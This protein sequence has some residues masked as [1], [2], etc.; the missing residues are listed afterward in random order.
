VNFYNSFGKKY[1][2]RFNLL[3]IVIIMI[4]TIPTGS[5]CLE[6]GEVHLDASAIEHDG[7]LIGL[8]MDHSGHAIMLNDAELY[9]DDGPGSGVPEGLD[10]RAKV[11]PWVEELKKGIVI[12]KILVLDNP[13]TFSARLLFEGTE[14]KGNRD[15]LHIS[16]N[17]IE[18]LRP[19]SLSAYPYTVQYTEY[20]PYDC[21]YFIDMP[22]GALRK[23]ENEVLLWAESDSTSWK[24]HISS[25][26]EFARGSLTRPH[27][28]NRS[29]KSSDGGKTWTD[30]RLGPMGTM[31]GE[32]SVRFNLNHY[33]SSGQYISPVMEM[34]NDLSPLKRKI[35]LEKFRFTAGIE[36]PE[37]TSAAVQVRFGS[38]PRSEDPSWTPWSASDNTKEFT[39]LGDRRYVQW[40]VD[41]STANPLKTP[42]IKECTLSASWEDLS[43]NEELGISVEVVHN[44]HVVR[45]SYPF[46][47]EN[48]LHPE[49]EKYRKNAQLD[50]IVEGA[51]SEFEVM[52]RL[53]NWAYR[54]PVTSDKYSWNWN[55]VTLLQKG[56]K[57][58]PR[59]QMDYKARRRDAMCLYSNQALIGALLAFGHQARHININSEA[60]SG[61]E[62][63][64][65]WSNEFNKWIYLDATRDYY[66][67]DRK[68]GIPLNLLEIHNLLAART[69]NPVT[70]DRPSIME[71]ETGTTPTDETSTII[72][73]PIDV[74]I[75]EGANPY[76]VVPD[77]RHLI[78]ITG[79]FRI[80]P[81]NDFLSHPVPA[82][83]HTGASA[84]GWDGFLN[85][86]DEKYPPRGEY[87]L[88]TGRALDFYEPLNQ[89]EVYLNET[90][91]RGALHV[92][93]NTFTP[94][95]ETFLV[96]LNEGKWVEQ[97]QPVWIWALK[98][99]KNC[100]QVRVKNLR[101]VLGPVSTLN[102]TYNP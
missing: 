72:I 63:T 87:H 21:W 39:G 4:L 64:E 75:R 37:G 65:V 40:K 34:V 31:D 11:R 86:Y 10:E 89:A 29:L 52:M 77:A 100:V 46:A 60:E 23:G 7:R 57:G 58:M 24:V 5:F 48:I 45:S 15:P 97:K 32:Y 73:S 99:G 69:K 83:V 25:E 38:S 84:W 90:G 54:I 43:P 91:E 3:L 93:V 51:S 53:L 42:K 62:V 36:T 98:P 13:A 22:V 74:G 20:A 68:T 35:R 19:P 6:T 76:S 102:V 44:G 101:G 18:F 94:G 85:Y 49:L 82:P 27:H 12:K 92:E 59:M 78:E 1:M 81:R 47:Y 33:V 66:Y 79:Y 17:G 61:H 8:R 96:R 80:I 56:E 41:L 28:P 30:S 9:E 95:F 70:W 14:A 16:L 50:K 71:K 88:E 2:N 67:F 55:D 26:K